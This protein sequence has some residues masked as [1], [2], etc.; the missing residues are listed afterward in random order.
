MISKSEYQ[1]TLQVSQLHRNANPPTQYMHVTL[2]EE[3][4]KVQNEKLPAQSNMIKQNQ[5]GATKI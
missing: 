1:M 4:R 3:N 2:D 5:D